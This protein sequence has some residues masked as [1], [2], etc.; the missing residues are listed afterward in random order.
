MELSKEEEKFLIHKLK[1]DFTWTGC[2]RKQ[3]DF[4]EKDYN[5][6]LSILTKLGAHPLTDKLGNE[7]K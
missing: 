3:Y 5:L 7:E 1:G 4:Y 2:M 6:L